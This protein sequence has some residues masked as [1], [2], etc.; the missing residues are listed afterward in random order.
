MDSQDQTFG[1]RWFAPEGIGSNAV[2]R[3]NGKRIVLRTAIS[4]GLWGTTGLIPSSEMATRQ[5]AAAKNYGMNMLNFHRA[6]GQ[7]LVFDKADEMGLLYFEE[8]GCYV[9]GSADP[10]C[11]L[12][13]RE[14]LLRMMKR[15][16]SHP[17]LVIYNMINE[18]WDKY[19][20][21]KDAALYANFKTDIADAHKIDPSRVIVL[22]SAWSRKPAGE[23][24]PVKLHMRPF[25]DRLY[26]SGWF[27][28]H[29]AGGPECW[30]QDDYVSPTKHYGFTAN[31]KE[32]VYWG[33]EGA[34]SSPPRLALIKKE[35]AG[36]SNPGW[37]GEIYLDWYRQFDEFLTRKNL[38]KP[39]PTVDSFCLALGAVAIEHQGR[40]IEDT[41]VCNLNDGYAINGW[42]AEPYENHSGVVDCF[43]NPKADPKI[44]AYY[45]QP[46][47]VA[48]KTRNQVVESGGSATV[49]FY[50]INESGVKGAHVLKVSAVD[51]SGAEVF[52]QE[53]PV[54][55]AGGETYGQILREAVT[56]P[57]TK[58][59]GLWTLKAQ[60]SDPAGHEVATGHD[61]ILVVNWRDTKLS[62]RGAVYEVDNAVRDFLK[63]RMGMDVPAYASE[64]GALDWIVVARATNDEPVTIPSEALLTPDGSKP[65]LLAT[66]YK[67]NDFANK[68]S[69]R[70]D[71]KVDFSWAEGATPD[72]A[73]SAGA[74]FCVR[75]EGKII[76]PR[77]GAYSFFTTNARGKAN[78]RID[79]AE[80]HGKSLNLTA[81]VP[82]SVVLDYIPKAGKSGLTLGWIVPVEK[83]E[84]PAELIGRAAKD[85][86]TIIIADHADSWMEAVKAAA[87]IKYDGSFKIGG[88][89]LGG[90]Y[91]AVKHPLFKDLPTD[92]ALNWPYQSVI[93][94]GRTRYGLSLEGE[95]LVAGCWQTFPM[96]LGTAVGVV[97]SG[98]GRIILST[99]DV[100]THLND[101]SGPA[102][103]ARK[104]LCNY[105]A[106]AKT[107][108][109]IQT[110]AE[111][112]G[113]VPTAL[114]NP[115]PTTFC[116]PLNLDYMIQPDPKI[117]YREAADPVCVYFKGNYFVFA[118]KSGGY[119]FS[120]DF[121]DWKL[122]TPP[123]LPLD[124]WAPA[125]FE[126]K[127]ALFFMAT[128]DGNIYRS[129]HP[130]DVGSWTVAGKVRGDQDPALFLDDD[131]RVYLYY[132]CHPFGPIS[133]VELDPN[134]HFAE[135]G[136]PV[137]LLWADL[138]ERGWERGAG[139]NYNGTKPYIEGAWMT[140]HA[141]HYYLQYAAPG[142]QWKIYGDGAA[143][144]DKPLG[145]FVYA[146]NSPVSFKPRGFLGSAGHSATFTDRDSNLW[147]IVTA[148]IGKTHGFERRLAVYPQ[149][150]DNMGR[151]FTRTVLGDYP[152]FLPGQKNHPE[153]GN[154]PGWMLLSFGKPVSASS[155]LSD[156]LATAAVDEDIRTWWSASG[157]VPGEWLSLDLGSQKSICAV[158]INF[159][160]Q[161]VAT[162]GRESGFAQRYLLEY[163]E[164]GKSWKTL[165]D[166]RDNKRDVP[167]DYLELL[168]P[169]TA[170][171]LKLT[172]AGRPGGGKFSVRDLRVF[173]AGKGAA[174][175]P[176]E[177]L[178]VQRNVTNRNEVTLSWSAA[179]GAEGTII[180]YGVAPDAL[181]NQ[182]EVRGANSLT[183]QS[184]NATPGYWF[185]AD[186]FNEAGVTTF[187]GK[188][189]AA[190]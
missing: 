95:E 187:Q 163:S 86:T 12:L 30:R 29:R 25:D 58:S 75:W 142:T 127:G 19:K 28:F 93:N 134:N 61:Q 160:E 91:F 53:F 24:E 111:K 69:E 159:A 50:L 113:E 10:F 83:R 43:R 167:H 149:G 108:K 162:R 16:R 70:T 72:A 157:T 129:E 94:T 172:D 154:A 130:E 138:K 60:M 78:L 100:C 115:K 31:E 178:S 32:I 48:V 188:P 146:D 56:I 71:P 104:L 150:F 106:F 141:G 145:P 122:I 2:F 148:V 47:Y 64:L 36:L 23:D 41:R 80:V 44:L 158:Q 125:V 74:E 1:F 179:L 68:L 103:V 92:V 21:D 79:G 183:I 173:G 18:Q 107:S 98:K 34:I 169:L 49:D 33:E 117:C 52:K 39:F 165:A 110:T 132:G 174:P 77:T 87:P 120:P 76:P 65:G 90:Q 57:A 168:K 118:S 164:D 35:I 184:L 180:R 22:A 112:H 161:D 59:V 9:T 20:A 135:I 176:I 189:V 84:N 14:K 175:Q 73:V 124:Q 185:A 26:L 139:E 181:W 99:L 81:G 166:K 136:E 140:K 151:M 4:W 152:Q 144:S 66:F 13:V 46:R 45:N 3:L 121:V 114:I 105:I 85:G 143:V 133:G 82:V 67:G 156:H 128:H 17:S 15:D 119:W 171:Y 8:P 155:S 63:T 7:P 126:Y 147:R 62:G 109:P 88:N 6:I 96:K 5:I 42:E 11:E 55:V 182:Y 54:D 190:P 170:R 97:P 38:R 123:N 37:D 89:W 51:A 27:D 102:D 131:G 40:K 116:N 137:D 177:K 186:S 153:N 101:S